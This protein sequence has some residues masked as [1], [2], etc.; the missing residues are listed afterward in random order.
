MTSLTGNAPPRLLVPET[1]EFQGAQF[2][3]DGK[4]LAFSANVSG[5]TE[6]Y[7]SPVPSGDEALQARWQVSGKGGDRPRWRAD[8]RELFYV[9]AD[10]MIMAVTVDGTGVEFRVVGEKALFQVFQRIL[11]QTICVTGDGERFVVNTLGGDEDEPLAVVTNWLQT[12][13]KQ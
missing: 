4:W 6:V 12:L 5:R 11:L 7:V 13:P 8:S 3:R 10:G 9:R 1:D 2:S